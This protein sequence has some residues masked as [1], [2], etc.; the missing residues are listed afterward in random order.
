MPVS[1]YSQVY[2][3]YDQAFANWVSRIKLM[4]RK[5]PTVFATP[6]RALSR[7]QDVLKKKGVTVPDVVPL[8][9]S[10]VNRTG[11]VLDPE[12]F[13]NFTFR[14][15]FFNNET[16]RYIKVQR[17]TPVKLTYQVHFWTRN[18]SH[19]DRVRDQ[20]LTQ[21]RFNE[22]YLTV[23]HPD[24]IGD[25]IVRVTLD[26]IQPA[27]PGDVG[28][29]QRALRRVFIFTVDAWIC[30]VPEELVPVEK[31][32]IEVATSQDLE[33]VEETI[34]TVEVPSSES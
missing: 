20:F 23:N 19:L 4:D 24:P 16:G 11:E 10:S 26:D 30:H 7:M 25:R 13:V 9:F 15:N 32:T 33:T 2:D 31:V 14:R 18:L 3:N 28:K 27:P 29:E 21:L 8:P 34:V 6:E 1:E 5:I 12:R 17:P 22:I